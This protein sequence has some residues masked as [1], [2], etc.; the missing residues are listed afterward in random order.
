M[1]TSPAS[2]SNANW[3]WDQV[4]IKDQNEL[5]A[6]INETNDSFAKEDRPLFFPYLFGGPAGSS[7]GASF[8]G[9]KGWHTKYEVA[10]SVM[11]GVVFNHKHHFDMLSEKLDTSKRI[12]ATGGSMQSPVWAQLV[13]DIFNRE[14]ELSDTQESGARGIAL[15]AGVGV[16]TYKSIDDAISK[17]V[18]IKSVVKPSNK[19][20]E[21]YE[22]RY[23]QYRA[24]AKRIIGV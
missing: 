4:G 7:T 3:Y 2:A 11:E 17:S 8:V 10:A 16:G 1:S 23:K 9:L 14:I 22:R 21:L 5:T 12:V 24:E 15:L 19:N 18:R 13:A 6:F 20:K